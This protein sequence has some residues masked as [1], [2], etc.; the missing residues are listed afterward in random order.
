[1]VRQAYREGLL[2]KNPCEFV[3]SPRGEAAIKD[4]PTPEELQLIANT[5]TE[6][7]EVKRGC[8]FTC[9]TGLR[10]CDVKALRF[11]HINFKERTIKVCQSETSKE[12]II[13]LNDTAIA[14]LREPKENLDLVFQL[15]S[16]NWCNK[17]DLLLRKRNKNLL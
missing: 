10:F 3:S 7:I 13:H 9:M 4:I 11:F 14:L 15:G 16:S 1:V 12:V 6:A 5:P 17:S 2:T 8:L